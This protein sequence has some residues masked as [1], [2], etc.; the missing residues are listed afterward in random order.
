M[1]AMINE[2]AAV[3]EVA[4]RARRRI[5]RRIMP[6]LFILYIIAYLDRVN[7]GFA[8]L[9]MKGD[10]GFNDAVFGLGTGIFFVGYFLLEIPGT[11]IVENWSARRWIAR[12]MISWGVV[13]MCTGFIHSSTQFYIVRLVLGAAEAGFFPG[14]IVYLTHWFRYEDRA[15]AVAMFM[16]AIPISNIVGAPLSG[17]ILGVKWLGLA[18]WRWLFILEGAP[19]IVLGVVT[20][21]YLTDWP[22]Q[23]R[24]LLEDER[25][26]ITSELEQEKLSKMATGSVVLAPE[27]RTLMGWLRAL[28][29]WI[30]WVVWQAM[31]NRDVI[32]LALSYFLIVTSVYGLNIWMPS[33]VKKVSGLSDW[34]VTLLSA[35]PYVAGLTAMLLL[36]RSSDRTGER[37]WHT[38]LP[39]MIAGTGLL[40]SLAAQNKVGLVIGAFCIAAIGLNGYLPGFWALPTRFLAGSAAAAAIGLIN[41]VGNLGGQVGPLIVGF[42]SQATGSFTGGMLFLSVSAIGAA[43]LILALRGS[44]RDARPLP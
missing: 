11:L 40:L 42:F 20:I 8:G 13:A 2:T 6:Y 33:M 19:A 25:N 28:M 32:L 17:L 16:A 14:I 1:K 30:G 5:V 10:L 21:F 7:V 38:A 27:S 29:R 26:W 23:A 37:R 43:V 39:M 15:K 34:R 35:I 4:E 24:W 12:I 3:P 18:G 36:G 9:Q 41:S 31:R 22:H 44:P